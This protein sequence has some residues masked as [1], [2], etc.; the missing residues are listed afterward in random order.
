MKNATIMVMIALLAAVV[1]AVFFFRE[2]ERIPGEQHTNTSGDSTAPLTP[3]RTAPELRPSSLPSVNRHAP[4]KRTGEEEVKEEIHF[5]VQPEIKTIIG[6]GSDFSYRAR[7]AAVH[8]LGNKLASPAI[9]ALCDFLR[10]RH[11]PEAGMTLMDFNAVKNEVLDSLISQKNL[12][13]GLGARILQMAD[14]PD[15]DW[16]WRDYCVQH[17]PEY[18]SR[19]WP[20]DKKEEDGPHQQKHEFIARCW[21][22]AE[23]PPGPL[24]GTALLSLERLKG[25][26]ADD[27]S[28]E[29]LGDTAVAVA[30]NS[31]APVTAR[32]PALQI[33][34]RLDCKSVLENAREL[35]LTGSPLNLR[36]SAIAAVGIIGG[37]DDLGLLK[38]ILDS[39][40]KHAHKAAAA[41]MKNIRERT[42]DAARI[43]PRGPEKG[44][45]R[46]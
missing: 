23:G 32:V 30:G 40:D 3:V 35:A 16:I 10:T 12:P 39:S 20:A 31:D 46:T 8:R 7:I 41:A 13:E 28:A 29:R 45:E 18:Y 15:T 24:T 27:F 21:E 34:S 42:V 44:N 11:T 6:H 22:Y 5:A 1:S 26:H 43:R 9:K 33:A 38:Q 14:D 36:I 37:E 17:L 2:P 25:S 19:R 4:G